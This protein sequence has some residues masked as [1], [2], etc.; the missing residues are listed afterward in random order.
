MTE[1]EIERIAEKTVQKMLDNIGIDPSEHK[2]I[3]AD[4]LFLRAQRKMYSDIGQHSI[5][6]LFTALLLGICAIVWT[7]IK[8]GRAP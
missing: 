3:R 4:F 7:A 1:D 6:A 8:S 2:E 5:K